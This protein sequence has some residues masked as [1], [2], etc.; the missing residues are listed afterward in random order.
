MHLF[1]NVQITPLRVLILYVFV[2]YMY[3]IRIFQLYIQLYIGSLNLTL[4]SSSITVITTQIVQIID[5]KNINLQI[6]NIKNMFLTL[7]LKT[8]KTCIKHKTQSLSAVSLSAPPI[9]M[10]PCKNRK[11]LNI[12]D[13]KRTNCNL[14][15]KMHH[16]FMWM[17]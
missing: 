1:N 8:L 17:F 4:R 11:V 14:L 5:V 6:K 10:F 12:T 13:R 15:K 7:I 2:T 16:T 9:Q 3:T